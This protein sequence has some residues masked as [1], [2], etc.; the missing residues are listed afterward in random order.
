MK[1]N[2]TRNLKKSDDYI[3][4]NLVG[5][6]NRQIQL[7]GTTTVDLKKTQSELLKSLKN[8]EPVK[9]PGHS[10]NNKSLAKILS[11]LDSKL[12]EL[13]NNFTNIKTNKYV[14][15]NE[16][17]EL[18]EFDKF[19]NDISGA[20]INFTYKNDYKINPLLKLNF[21]NIEKVNLLLKEL[22]KVVN[23]K[24]REEKISLNNVNKLNPDELKQLSN[25]KER[26]EK[27]SLD[28][29]DKLKVTNDLTNFKERIEK[30]SINSIE[31]IKPDTDMYDFKERTEFINLENINNL[32]PDSDSSLELDAS[33]YENKLQITND[34][35]FQNSNY[36]KEFINRIENELVYIEKIV[37]DLKIRIIYFKN[38][39]N[40][41]KIKEEVTKFIKIEKIDI[42]EFETVTGLDHDIKFNQVNLIDKEITIKNN[43]Y[44]MS[45]EEIFTNEEFLIQSGSGEKLNDFFNVAM[46]YNELLKKRKII[47]ELKQVIEEYNLIY[48][49]YYYYQLFIIKNINRFKGENKIYQILNKKSLLTYLNIL[50]KLNDIILKP[51]DIFSDINSRQRNVHSIFFFRYYH[52]IKILFVFFNT[53]KEVWEKNN[54]DETYKINFYDSKEMAK[55][56]IIFNFSYKILLKYEDEFLQTLKI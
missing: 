8:I 14:S 20:N 33:I 50:N 34:Y 1:K 4:E 6:R 53:I 51:E 25:F 23:F 46:K 19:I 7:G 21:Q 35:M 22:E 42:P 45:N 18:S 27:L 49:Q 28:N 26:L 38:E 52:V 55:Y 15:T 44:S 40:P 29:I 47:I 56:I 3:L 37:K 2:N 16:M 24:E 54:Y 5:K 17:P 30:I 31:K 12:Q 13:N 32:T 41:I 10:N 39:M 43:K 9:S 48:I 36:T 11:S